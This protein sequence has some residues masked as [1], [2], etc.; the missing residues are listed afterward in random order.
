MNRIIFFILCLFLIGFTFAQTT[1]KP[2]PKIETYTYNGKKVSK[3][4]LLE[5]LNKDLVEFCKK[6]KKSKKS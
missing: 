3:Q 5:L 4:Q 6:E 1:P 2:N